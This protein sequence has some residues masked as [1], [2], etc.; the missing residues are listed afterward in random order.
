MNK[1]RV[2]IEPVA[3][4]E[5]VNHLTIRFSLTNTGD[6]GL[7]VLKWK[8]PLEGLKS[9][10]LTVIADGKIVSYDGILV[11][12]IRPS[13]ESYVL[14]QPGETESVVVDVSRAYS[15]PPG[16]NVQVDF[17]VT[18]LQVIEEGKPSLFSIADT[19]A[20]VADVETHPAAFV[21]SSSANFSPTIGQANRDEDEK[22][23]PNEFV[24]PDL[25]AIGRAK[26]PDV[27][28]DDAVKKSTITKAHHSGYK[29]AKKA[30]GV[31]RSDDRYDQWFGDFT[32][33]RHEK[34]RSNLAKII[35]RMESATFIYFTDGPECDSDTYAYT[36]LG[37]LRI[38]LCT[39]FWNAPAE[40]DES[41]AGTMVHEHSHA[42][43]RTDDYEYGK[44][45]CMTLARNNPV[46]AIRNADS[47]EYFAE[48]I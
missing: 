29:L 24:E 40:G 20:D 21:V 45:D 23:S 28:T 14:I 44:R 37:S 33:A 5:N 7:H 25:L 8:T 48:S 32:D 22:K 1:L 11:K 38:Y 16:A 19:P 10:C 41:K 31:L 43:S 6:R 39:G 17:D 46:K 4:P 34:V 9:D 12:R 13:S 2:T 15:I 42:T 47:Y 3:Q 18:R 35:E 36:T 26:D 30:L 27:R